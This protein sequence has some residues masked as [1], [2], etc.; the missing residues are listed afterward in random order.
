MPKPRKKAHPPKRKPRLRISKRKILQR[1]PCSQ[2][3]RLIRQIFGKAETITLTPTRVE[4]IL[5]KCPPVS[6][7]SWFLY[8]FAYDAWCIFSTWDTTHYYGSSHVRRKKL[9][10]VLMKNG[11]NEEIA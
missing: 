6:H 8:R 9:F 4:R 1:E 5:K 10:S 3:R 11:F 7:L 2:G